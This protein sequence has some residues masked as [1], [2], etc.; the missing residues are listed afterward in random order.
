MGYLDRCELYRQIEQVRGRPV[1][2]FVTSLRTNASG[3]IAADVIPE[4]VRQLSS[5]PDDAEEVDVLLVSNGGDPIVAWRIASLLRERFRRYNV[6]LPYSAY[7]AATLLALGADTIVMHP[8]ASLGPVDPQLTSARRSEDGLAQ[9]INQFGAEDLVHFLGFVR[10]NVGITDQEQLEKAFELLCKDVGALAIGSA[11]RSSQLMLSLSERLL[12]L[13][14]A[15]LKEA[16]TIAESLSRSYYHHG[17]SV[18]PK[19][20]KELRLAIETPTADVQDLMWKVWQDLSDEMYCA[21]PFDPMEIVF[22]HPGAA[23]ALSSVNFVNLPSNLPP[24][25]MQ[26]VLTQV[27]Q[28]ITVYP[29]VPVDFS[30][31]FAAVESRKCHSHYRQQGEIRAVRLPDMSIQL[32]VTSKFQKWIFRENDA[33]AENRA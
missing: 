3:Q 28:Q 9:Q 18:G 15:D 17:Y 6:L 20:A 30:I 24:P 21:E 2:S 27:L 33:L 13:H 4:V 32:N 26:Q 25:V 22:A 16:Q 31:F 11:K 7:S 10:D 23:Q 1:I 8:F 29:V 5:V 14:M 12:R 19:E